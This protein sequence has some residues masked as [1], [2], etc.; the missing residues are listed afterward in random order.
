M[1]LCRNEWGVSRMVGR[2][3]ERAV[4][5]DLEALDVA[6][7]AADEERRERREDEGPEEPAR[8]HG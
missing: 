1:V 7:R 3:E 2:E 6:E 8:G 5:E 4:R